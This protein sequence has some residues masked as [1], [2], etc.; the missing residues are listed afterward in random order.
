MI[1]IGP[2]EKVPTIAPSS[3]DTSGGVAEIGLSAKTVWREC[4]GGQRT[5]GKVKF[6]HKM[7]K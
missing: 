3:V 2:E 7:I 5:N 4:L 1:P 6:P